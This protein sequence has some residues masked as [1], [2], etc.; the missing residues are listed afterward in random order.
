MRYTI[1]MLGA[2]GNGLMLERN[3]D[4]TALEFAS[5]AD[6]LAFAR[7]RKTGWFFDDNCR[8]VRRAVKRFLLTDT[9]L[10]QHWTLDTD[11]K[12]IAK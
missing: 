5:L 6:A 8:F 2:A 4:E 3:T 10:H 1:I 12:E 9:V 7:S 11:G